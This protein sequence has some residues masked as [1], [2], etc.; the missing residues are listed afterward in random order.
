MKPKS[1][2]K[3]AENQSQITEQP[4]DFEFKLTE[5][6]VAQICRSVGF[7]STEISA[8][9]ALTE[10]T[11]LYLKTLAKSAASY[12]NAANRTESNIFDIINALHDLVS[13]HSGFIGAST[14]HNNSNPL[15]S[16]VVKDL[17]I[18]ASSVDEIPFAKPIPRRIQNSIPLHPISEFRS[19]HIPKWLPA[20]PEEVT[21]KK[22]KEIKG[23]KRIE[24]DLELWENSELVKSCGGTGNE[25]EPEKE[26]K[27]KKNGGSNLAMERNR[28]RFKF[29]DVEI[30]GRRN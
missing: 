29:G 11:T 7:K 25:V 16:R 13:I 20:F 22:G 15:S 14:L 17:S 18:F 24:K 30:G 19:I 1:K 10:I 5:L 4:K 8:F 2:K 3:K 9:K 28:I 26:K 27:K 6:A 23:D 21:Y 12:S